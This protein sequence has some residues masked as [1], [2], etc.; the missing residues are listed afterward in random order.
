MLVRRQRGGAIGR[1]RRLYHMK[2]AAWRLPEARRSHRGR[3]RRRKIKSRQI[4]A[5]KK[6]KYGATSYG[7]ENT[8]SHQ[9][10]RSL[11]ELEHHLEESGL[12][13][14]ASAHACGV[15]L[16]VVHAKTTACISIRQL[17]TKTKK[18]DANA[19]RRRPPQL[20][21]CIR[22]LT[23][24]MTGW[25]AACRRRKRPSLWPPETRPPTISATSQRR[26]P[27]YILP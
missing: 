17:V 13:E 8:A 7:A 26:V 15:A 10:L 27:A 2:A 16:S 12:Y 11:A 19:S 5:K 23:G 24:E 1:I 25:Q 3:W 18:P 22:R 21:L 4:S 20:Y 14:A 9:A 6:R